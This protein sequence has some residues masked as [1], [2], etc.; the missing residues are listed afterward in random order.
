MSE[1]CEQTDE[2][3]CIESYRFSVH[4]FLSPSSGGSVGRAEA[5]L[6]ICSSSTLA[7]VVALAADAIIPKAMV[8]ET[9]LLSSNRLVAVKVF[10]VL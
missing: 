6:Y 4:H 3:T 8:V 5:D 2:F 10:Y 1:R 9:S 7:A